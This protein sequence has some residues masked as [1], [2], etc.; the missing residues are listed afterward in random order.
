MAGRGESVDELTLALSVAGCAPLARALGRVFATVDVVPGA[1]ITHVVG[2]LEA[3]RQVR[4]GLN[5]KTVLEVAFGSALAG[6]PAAVLL[7]HNG[8]AVALDALANAAVHSV[9]APLVLVIG[10]DP[11]LASSTSTTDTRR[12]AQAA[13]VPLIEVMGLGDEGQAV[14]AAARASAVSGLPVIIRFTASLHDSCNA[15]AQVPAGL[16]GHWL[17]RVVGAAGDLTWPAGLRPGGRPVGDVAHGLTK[18]GRLQWID[19]IALPAAVESLE[20][21]VADYWQCGGGPCAVVAVGGAAQVL[22]H[23]SACWVATSRSVPLSPAVISFV[24]RHK[25][26]LVLEEGEPIVEYELARCVP[27]VVRGKLTGDLPA[28]GRVGRQ[29][30]AVALAAAFTPPLAPEAKSGSDIERGRLD[31]LWS[32]VAGLRHRGMF[33]ATDVGS[34]V[35]LCYPPYQGADAALA[36]GSSP[37]V[38][39]GAAAA[40]D[41]PAIAV[42]GDFGL[43]HSGIGGL[44]EIALR[45]LPVVVVVLV[46]GVQAKTGGQPVPGVDL[47]RLV[48]G[49]GID[50]VWHRMASDLHVE[51]FTQELGQ[52]AARRIPT[53]VLVHDVGSGVRS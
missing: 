32:A 2:L 12:L 10:D 41:Q 24:R 20:A 30:V 42:I 50:S 35:Q 27:G 15:P 49:C 11:D 14:D 21:D 31:V 38:A 37:A 46:N 43:L 17:S 29:E 47:G 40:R 22:P 6:K 3:T 19:R 9:S 18:R 26:V 52:Q 4:Y 13:H 23:D 25:D 8:L 28:N 48:R 33:V 45:G 5:E 1:P 53:V 36:L 39:A 51:A 34:S 16:K 7:K 44:V